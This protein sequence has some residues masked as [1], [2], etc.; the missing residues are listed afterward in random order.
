M[1]EAMSV[2]GDLE[3]KFGG[4]RGA[5]ASGAWK[6]VT[7]TVA[8][9]ARVSGVVVAQYPFGVFADIGVGFPALLLVTRFAKSGIEPIM[10]DRSPKIG[11][12][13]HARVLGF[14]DRERTIVLS[15]REGEPVLGG[16]TAIA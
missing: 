8:L 16:A 7:T 5:A 14:A 4:Y 9:E 13:L 3:A 6:K 11:E 15:Q 1:A 12:P 10:R 2:Q